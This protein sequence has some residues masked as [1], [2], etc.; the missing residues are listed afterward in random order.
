[1]VTTPI[2]NAT[3]GATSSSAS[4]DAGTKTLTL[5]L[6]DGDTASDIVTAIGVN[7]DFTFAAVAGA[8]TVT[9]GDAGTFTGKLT[10]GTNT[11]TPTSGSLFGS[12][13]WSC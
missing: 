3:T 5:A 10:G 9:T 11:L 2:I 8:Q 13:W 6:K 12:Q 4:D 7:A 1:M